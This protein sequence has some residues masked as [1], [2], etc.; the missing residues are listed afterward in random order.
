MSGFEVLEHIRDDATLA[1]LPVVVFTGKELSPEEDARLH[2]L[3]RS[4]VVKGV[5][6]PER[7]LDETA[8][9]LH[10]VLADLPPE[11][12][13]MLDRLHRS[14]DDLVGKKVL[15]V[16][17]DVRNIFALSSVLERR[18]ME[19][20]TA[21]TGHEAIA[22]LEATPDVA[23]VLMDI[24]MPEMDGYQ[25][26]HAIRQ[27][28]PLPA[29]ADH[30]ADRQG[31][32]GRPREVPGS[33]GL[34]LPGQAGQHRAAAV[35]AA[36]VA[37]PLGGRADG[38]ANDK[39]NILLVDDQPGKLLSYEA[40]LGDLG[41]NLIKASSGTRSP[42][43]SAQDRHHDRADG[44]QHAGARRLR[45]GGDHPPA[46]PLSEDGDHLRLGGAPDRPGPAQ[47]LR[48]RARWT[49]S[50]SRSSRSC[51]AP[52]SGSSPSSTARRGSWSG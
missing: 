52:R 30:R 50:R 47:G 46:P 24:M 6:S 39:V 48:V 42:G 22:T 36:H 4:V 20:L 9:F 7:L 32:E 33:R 26:M 34:R 11:K 17:D 3:A 19:V 27:K 21:G 49:T 8:L 10:R 51:C 38:T 35:R 31:D 28:P 18:G 2:T 37:A 1:D 13:Q 16:D 25:T 41:E 23:I 5:E 45:A 29:A 40:M 44:R 14:D 15:V 12:Q 43:A